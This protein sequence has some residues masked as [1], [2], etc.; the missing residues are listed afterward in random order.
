DRAGKE[1][2][3][4]TSGRSDSRGAMMTTQTRSARAI[5][6][7]GLAILMV[8]PPGAHAEV[9]RTGDEPCDRE[10]TIDARWEAEV[11]FAKAV[12]KHHE[13]L[14]VDA[15]EL[16]EQALALWDNPDIH[17]NLALVLD[18]LGKYLLAHEQLASA[19]RWDTELG[20]ERLTEVR[21]RMRMLETK[22]LA[23]IEAH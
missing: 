13:L 7:A 12:N 21:E 23:R 9:Q 4:G 10:A 8:A 11:L 20:N 14:R 3:L 5:A 15:M 19:L 1:A 22:R 6:A 18:D 16:Y 2:A 17:W